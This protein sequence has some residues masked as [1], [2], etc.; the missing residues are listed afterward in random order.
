M[1]QSG[2]RLW[3]PREPTWPWYF[4][5]K[6]RAYFYFLWHLTPF[7]IICEVVVYPTAEVVDVSQLNDLFSLLGSPLGVRCETRVRNDQTALQ[8]HSQY[9]SQ[10]SHRSRTDA[11]LGIPMVLD[12]AGPKEWNR[13][14]CAS[15]ED[16]IN[17]PVFPV[18]A[19]AP[20]SGHSSCIE[21]VG[22]ERFELL[23][24]DLLQ[25]GRIDSQSLD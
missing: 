18:R 4:D 12:L 25:K 22:N 11:L 9:A 13:S 8:R 3:F 14:T 2:Q 24:T 21:A 5:P 16:K 15:G 7:G 17:S 1:T 6:A 23:W 10:F 19:S 20:N